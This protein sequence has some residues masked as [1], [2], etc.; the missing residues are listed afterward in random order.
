MK[1]HVIVGT[2]CLHCVTLSA[3]AIASS[4][5]LLGCCHA[6]CVINPC[7]EPADLDTLKD[8][9]LSSCNTCL[10]AA[11]T[12][13]LGDVSI[14]D[15]NAQRQAAFLQVTAGLMGIAQTLLR[16]STM[17]GVAYNSRYGRTLS[18]HMPNAACM[19]GYSC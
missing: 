12:V 14:V 18:L 6:L 9:G 10:Q 17:D 19:Q 1:S 16:I 2:C 8:A 11:F 13:L 7:Q 15:F 3:P 4:M 5:Q